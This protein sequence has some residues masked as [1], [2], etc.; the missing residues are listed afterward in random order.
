MLIG[1]A[2]DRTLLNKVFEKYSI[3]ESDLQKIETEYVKQLKGIL[4]SLSSCEELSSCAERSGVTGSIAAD[5]FRDC[6]RNDK[7][8]PALPG[9]RELLGEIAGQA[10]SDAAVNSLITSNLFVGARTKLEAVDLWTRADGTH[11]FTG[12]GFGDYPE[13]KWDTAE[14]ARKEL[15]DLLK[16][17]IPAHDVVLIGD[18]VYDIKT[19]RACGYRVISVCTGFTPA[20]LLREA[21]PDAIFKDLSDTKAVLDIIE[22]FGELR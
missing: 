2:M 1:R 22:D 3:P 12:G 10:G 16:R 21:K 5:G 4:L 18:S 17:N 9:V 13:E 15:E 19:A 8:L 7:V 14:R 6:A 11:Y 20:E